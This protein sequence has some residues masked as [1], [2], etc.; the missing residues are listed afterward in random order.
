MCTTTTY[1]AW[2]VTSECG[3]GEPGV[4]IL[5]N[6]VDA[7]GDFLPH[8]YRLMAESG[9]RSEYWGIVPDSP[10]VPM[11][12]ETQADAQLD[13]LGWQR[14]SEWRRANSGGWHAAVHAA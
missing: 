14:V 5:S 9:E 6:E 12:D 2:A 10:H 4:V 1:T 7:N 8:S 11:L 3:L 13:I